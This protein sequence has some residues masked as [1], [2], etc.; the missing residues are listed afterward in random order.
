MSERYLSFRKNSPELQELREWWEALN[1]NRGER[2]ELRRCHS[3]AE[4]V[5]SPAYHQ[6]RRVVE[7]YGRVDYD[8][9]ALVAGLVARIKTYTYGISVAEQMATGKQDGSARV[10][11]LR[12]RRLLKVKEKE[13][14]LG[15][16]TRVIALLGGAADIQSLAQGMYFWNDSTRKDWA[17]QYYSKGPQE[18]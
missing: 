6:L 9:L 4:V 13:E 17:F 16:M 5:F 15:V 12:F 2:A 14:L 10:S 7:G 8:G 1:E 3:L 11:G 18:K